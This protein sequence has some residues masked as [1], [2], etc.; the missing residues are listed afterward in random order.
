LENWLTILRVILHLIA[1]LLMKIE[2]VALATVVACITALALLAGQNRDP[3]RGSS[4]SN[5]RP[6]TA[7]PSPPSM[8]SLDVNVRYG[9]PYDYTRDQ[10]R[11]QVDND[12]ESSD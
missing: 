5:G 3:P 1:F 4:S 10:F 7:G 6:N 11:F 12:V 2:K 9:D 8:T